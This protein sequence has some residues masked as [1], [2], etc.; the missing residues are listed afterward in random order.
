VFAAFLISASALLPS[1][2]MEEAYSCS[3]TEPFWSMQI[4]NSAATLT[5]H[6]DMSLQYSPLTVMQST[7]DGRVKTLRYN[8]N[9]TPDVVM[10][11]EQTDNC[12]D[13][14]SDKNYAYRLIYSGPFYDQKNAALAG[15]CTRTK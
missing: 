5:D 8:S 14:M 6:A 2:G 3:G 10:T 12:S 15:C 9:D 1:K 4:E 7:N 11:L 13:G